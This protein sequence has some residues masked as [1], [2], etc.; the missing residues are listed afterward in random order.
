MTK[1]HPDIIAA[2]KAVYELR[3]KT[4]FGVCVQLGPWEGEPNAFHEEVI[5]EVAAVFKLALNGAASADVIA[6]ASHY[7][8]HEENYRAMAAQRLKELGLG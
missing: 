4:A 2:A 8:P 6:A 1:H 7:K 5:A 3:R